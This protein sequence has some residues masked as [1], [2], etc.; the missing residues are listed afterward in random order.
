MNIYIGNLSYKVEEAELKALFEQYGEVTSLKL[1]TDRQTGRQKGFGFIEMDD[2]AG[3]K[4]IDALNE[5]DFMGRNLKVNQ[6]RYTK[7]ELPR[8]DRKTSYR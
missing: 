1:I 8:E 5:K 3:Q 6:A 7:E 2:D 4:A